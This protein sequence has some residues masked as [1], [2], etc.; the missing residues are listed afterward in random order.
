[1][2][3]SRKISKIYFHFNI[4]Y[5]IFQTYSKV[6]TELPYIYQLDSIINSLLYLS[7]IYP[8]STIYTFLSKKS[9]VQNSAYMLSFEEKSE[10]K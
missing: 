2:N 9:K 8:P 5:E 10:E 7:C 6:E 3:C 4:W 1:M